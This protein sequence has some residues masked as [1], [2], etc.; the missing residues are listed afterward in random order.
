MKL[1]IENVLSRERKGM[2]MKIKD[3]LAAVVKRKDQFIYEYEAKNFLTVQEEGKKMENLHNKMK[4]LINE[5][6]VERNIE[7][8]EQMLK[9]QY[10][11][12]GIILY[13]KTIGRANIELQDKVKLPVY[14]Y[15]SFRG[16]YKEYFKEHL[17]EAE[18]RD[19]PSEK[20]KRAKKV[21][22]EV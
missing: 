19:Q 9:G 10:C 3:Q 8:M 16:I 18:K 12:E 13:S 14:H 21:M 5:D 7:L 6:G 4:Q 11:K 15:G 22:S 17:I 20:E 1:R 2:S